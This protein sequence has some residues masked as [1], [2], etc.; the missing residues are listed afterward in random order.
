[1]SKKRFLSAALGMLLLLTMSALGALAMGEI[2]AAT[3]S[4]MSVRYTYINQ[5]ST[6]A[7][8]F[9]KRN[10]HCVW[11]C[12]KNTGREKYLSLVNLAALF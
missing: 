2:N 4:E 11:V 8:Y 9:I 3:E 6:S 1:M 10:G 7:H 12:A 5:A